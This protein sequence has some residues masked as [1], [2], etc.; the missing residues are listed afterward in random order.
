M[1]SL[2][3]VDVFRLS[4]RFTKNYFKLKQKKKKETFSSA[5]WFC[6]TSFAQSV[7]RFDLV[8]V[9]RCS[10]L[11][12]IQHTTK[13]KWCGWVDCS[14]NTNQNNNE[15]YRRW[16]S[17]ETKSMPLFVEEKSVRCCCVKHKNK[18]KRNGKKTMKMSTFRTKRS[19]AYFHC[20]ATAFQLFFAFKM[21]SWLL[22]THLCR[23]SWL[24]SV[25]SSLIDSLNLRI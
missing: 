5:A 25:F 22:T 23:P 18:R 3:A 19:A 8:F 21:F 9:M 17:N 11:A 7:G 15:P 20:V 16:K 13:I 14:T 6:S 4:C 10:L 1:H 2:K 12:L 24:L